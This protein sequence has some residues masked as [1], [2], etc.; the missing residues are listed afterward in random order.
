MT[1]VVCAV[2][3]LMA[4]TEGRLYPPPRFAWTSIV[5]TKGSTSI[6][7]V[8]MVGKASAAREERRGDIS[9]QIIFSQ[10]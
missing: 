5:D 6:D 4:L 2:V 10:G 9:D 3:L 7:L 1:P 8:G